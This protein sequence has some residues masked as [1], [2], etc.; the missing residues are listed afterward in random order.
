MDVSSHLVEVVVAQAVGKIQVWWIPRNRIPTGR[1]I[2]PYIHDVRVCVGVSV[3]EREMDRDGES[4]VRTAGAG[5]FLLCTIQAHR[6]AE[7]TDPG[8]SLGLEEILR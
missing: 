2:K 1:R 5:A 3:C 4:R 6:E 7:T 8:I